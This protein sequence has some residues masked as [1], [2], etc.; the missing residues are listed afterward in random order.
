[1]MRIT[2][3]ASKLP[4]FCTLFQIILIQQLSLHSPPLFV[5]LSC[6]YAQ[7]FCARPRK[8]GGT[9]SND[10]GA[11]C[12]HRLKVA[13]VLLTPQSIR[14]S[15]Q[16]VAIKVLPLLDQN[17]QK[18]APISRLLK[19]L[20]QIAKEKQKYWLSLATTHTSHLAHKVHPIFLPK[21]NV[22]KS[23]IPAISW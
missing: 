11:Y 19:N 15:P 22:M 17:G 2:F 18:F 3:G 16:S 8:K 9:K 10:V 4:K 6:F 21:K 1:M 12:Y 20:H 7:T 23:K 14:I 5:S 13:K